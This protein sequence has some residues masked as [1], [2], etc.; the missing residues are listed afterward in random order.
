MNFEKKYRKLN[1]YVFSIVLILLAWITSYFTITFIGYR[2]V[3]LIFLLVVS[4]TAMLFEIYAVLT[5]ALLSAVILNFFFIPPLYTFHIGNTEDVLMFFMYLFIALINGVLNFK[6][7]EIERKKREQEEKNKTIQL[8]NTLLNSLSHELR[9]PIS[10][11]IGAVDTIKDKNLKIS[12]LNREELYSEIEVAS[13][14]LN[15]QVENLLSMSRLEAGTLKPKLDWVDINELMYHVIDLDVDKNHQILFQSDD[16]I[17]TIKTDGGFIE[18]IVHNLL[19]NAIQHTPEGT[20]ISIKTEYIEQNLNITISDSG[21]GFPPEEM[22]LVFNK[23]YKLHGTATGGTGLGLSIVKGFIEALNGSIQLTN[24]PSGGACFLIKIPA[25][26][27]TI[28]N[29]ENE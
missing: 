27:S 14:R 21:K 3:A 2:G 28:K 24:L 5:A 20:T 7:R 4:I 16:Q 6:I 13:L 26:I 25:E 8:Y 1:Q 15:R 18:T 22:N 12:N 17:L 9:T 11:I 29:Y 19:H 23:F 10:A